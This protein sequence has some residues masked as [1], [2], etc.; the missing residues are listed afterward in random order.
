MKTPKKQPHPFTYI[1]WIS[2]AAFG[3]SPHA[4]TWTSNRA[5]Y[6]VVWSVIDYRYSV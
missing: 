1:I 5:I 2:C 3:V 4:D 6:D